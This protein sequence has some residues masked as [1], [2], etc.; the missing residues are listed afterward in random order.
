MIELKSVNHYYGKFH[1]LKNVSFSIPKGDICGFIG[2]NGAGKSTALRILA[3][4]QVPTA[5]DVVL[6]GH[7]MLTEPQK[8]RACLGYMPETPYLYKELKVLEYLDY[9]GKLKGMP[10]DEIKRQNIELIGL[11]GLQK[12]SHKLVGQLSKGNRQRV[13]LA[14]ALLGKPQVLLLDEPM[15]AMDPAQTIEIRNLIRSFHGDI[16]VFFSSHVLSEIHQICDY[17][18][19]IRDGEID[20]A[21]IPSEMSV[22]KAN[23]HFLVVIFESLTE[24]EKKLVTGIAGGK[25]SQIPVQPNALM[26][27]VID[28]EKFF[29]ELYRTVATHQLK[30]REVKAR[31]MTLETL[32]GSTS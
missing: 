7:S 9:V 19:Y 21:G 1:V 12:I 26:V 31:E 30:L 22:F 27:S 23:K 8:T 20:Y 4:Y 5:G 11:C 10:N 32:F 3:G 2:P 28:R 13:A 18:V 29:T 25:W 14:Q 16:T 24:A 17:I 6:C 15:S